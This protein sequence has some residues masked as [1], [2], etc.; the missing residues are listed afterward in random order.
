MQNNDT[1]TVLIKELKQLRFITWQGPFT[2][3]LLFRVQFETDLMF[4]VFMHGEISAINSIVFNL[5]GTFSCIFSPIPWG[6][7]VFLHAIAK[8][9]RQPHLAFVKLNLFID[10]CCL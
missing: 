10:F 9:V 2:L 5:Q 4:M 1:D 3:N 6:Y 8:L 7:R